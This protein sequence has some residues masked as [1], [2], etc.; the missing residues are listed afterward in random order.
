MRLVVKSRSTRNLPLILDGFFPLSL[1]A[2]GILANY[3]RQQI[4][5]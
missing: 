4:E 1:N 2:A 5:T 3:Q